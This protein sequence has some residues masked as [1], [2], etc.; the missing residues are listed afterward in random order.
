MEAKK[1]WISTKEAAERLSVTTARVRQ[2]VAEKQVTAQKV[3]GKYRG[4]WLIKASDIEKRLSKLS[5]KGVHAMRVKGRMTPNPVVVSPNT[6]YNEALHLMRSNGIKHL[7]VLNKKDELV[8]IVA[9]ADMLE[10]EPSPVTTLSVYEMASLL[11]KVTIS[12]IMTSPVYAVEEDCSITNAAKFMIEK[13]IGCLP[14]IR[15]GE[16]VGIITDT[17]VVKTFVEIT[18]GEQSGTHVEL[19]TPDRKG[20]IARVCTAFANANSYIVS[21]AI[22]Y[23]DNSDYAYV[24]IK[25]RGAIADALQAEIAKLDDIEIVEMRPV[26]SDELLSF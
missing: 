13:E 24:D 2:M 17:D 25:E 4:Q 23:S 3:G 5:K 22:T 19:K 11:E 12:K 14:V 10:A 6:S 26:N 1:E 8:G 9:H 7:P 21:I 20:E 16:L 15:N 18:G